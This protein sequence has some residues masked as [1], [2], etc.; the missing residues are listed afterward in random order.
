MKTNITGIS[1][2]RIAYYAA[3]EIVKN[4]KTLIIV[5]RA[6][7][8]ER[9]RDDISFFVHDRAIYVMPEEDDLQIIYE[10]KDSNMLVQRIQAVDSLVS[11]DK[12]VV[13]APVSAALR[14]LQ[15]VERFMESVI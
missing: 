10:A 1:G 7:V 9:L 5:S 2:S 11:D 12:T 13:I 8:A 6:N 4:N 14:P 15:P 3:K